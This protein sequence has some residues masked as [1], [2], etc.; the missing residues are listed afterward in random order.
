MTLSRHSQ[1][2][3][4]RIVPPTWA[5]VPIW[6][7]PPYNVEPEHIKELKDAG[8]VQTVI[9]LKTRDNGAL[10]WRRTPEPA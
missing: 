4:D 8:L 6:R 10:L 9:S 7:R 5:L 3:L 1:F 2:L